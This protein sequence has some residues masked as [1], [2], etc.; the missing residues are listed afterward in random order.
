MGQRYGFFPNLIPYI[1][2][3]PSGRNF[4]FNSR[5]GWPPPVEEKDSSGRIRGLLRSKQMFPP[6]ES[7]SSSVGVFFFLRGKGKISPVG[8]NILNII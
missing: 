6:V 7:F 2:R 3:N 4:G 8:I 1:Y 5:S